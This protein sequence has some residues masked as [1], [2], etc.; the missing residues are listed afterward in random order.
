MTE[1]ITSSVVRVTPDLARAWLKNNTRNR[2][3]SAVVVKRYAETMARGEWTLNGE[4]VIFGDDGCLSSGQ[5]R[6]EAC[7]RANTPFTTLVVRGA[8]AETFTTLDTH[9]VRTA[10]DVLSIKG[11]KNAHTLGAA[12][13][14]F[15]TLVQGRMAAKASTPLEV[16][17]CVEDHP[18]L[19]KWVV[20]YVSFK[21][22]RL[23]SA[24][25]GLVI[26]IEEVHGEALAEVFFTK[27][28][29]GLDLSIT[30][31][32]YW[33]R[34][35]VNSARDQSATIGPNTLT[36]LAIKAANA[37]ILGRIVKNL[38]VA[39]NEKFPTLIGY[40]E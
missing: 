14:G 5:H 4:P 3:L 7:I 35:R 13:R 16:S 1:K 21:G 32:E 12:A 37:R 40:E 25:L 11:H 29:L 6:L 24:L 34:N 9:R 23:N 17:R 33:L 22:Q 39:E 20:R 10:S 30:D 26:A 27:A 15:L 28:F 19:S 31:G 2:P 8:P 38:K 18:T 36:H